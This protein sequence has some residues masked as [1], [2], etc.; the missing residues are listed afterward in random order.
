MNILGRSA[1]RA[2]LVAGLMSVAMT[3]SAQ[4]APAD[5]ISAR[6]AAMKTLGGEMKAIGDAAKAGS[7]TK[8]DALA[9]SRK[10]NDI[11]NQMNSWFPRGSGSESGVKTAASPA[12]WEKPADFKAAI[13]RLAQETAKLVAAADTGQAAA[14]ATQHAEVGK[15]CGGCHQPFRVRQ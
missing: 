6:Q 9:R 13:D 8:D 12:I 5:V 15:S 7:I 10:L 1:I 2:A 3:A 4:Q 11:A 14:I